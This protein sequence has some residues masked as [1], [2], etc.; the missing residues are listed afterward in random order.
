MSD[1][2]EA[3]RN[4]TAT[5]PSDA[6]L[7]FVRKL[8]ERAASPYQ[9]VSEFWWRF[10]KTKLTRDPLFRTLLS[11][12]A[13]PSASCLVDLGCGKGLLAAWLKGAH[14]AWLSSEM[15]PSWPAHWPQP[16]KI[17]T[18]LGVDR[19]RRDIARAKPAM[20]PYARVFRG[21]LRKVGLTMLDRCDVV[22][23]L[24]VL[25]YLDLPSQDRLLTAVAAALPPWGVVVLRVG[26]G[27]ALASRWVNA[28]D[29]VVSTLGGNPR[30]RVHRRSLP[31]WR[32]LFE[33]LGFTVEVLHDERAG[34]ATHRFAN[35]LLRA[36]RTAAAVEATAAAEAQEPVR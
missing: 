21:D 15:R 7:A 3:S 4:A 35:V 32:D 27:T 5:K 26:D 20:A 1:V 14:D 29:I 34:G 23:L 30:W 19:S 16:P 8:A 18:Y 6:E 2:A 11:T 28:V 31:G 36:T 10:A 24:D 17:G 13:I 22:T 25:H 33:R 9:R 12:G